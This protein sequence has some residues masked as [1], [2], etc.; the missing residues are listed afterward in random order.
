VDDQPK[1]NQDWRVLGGD[2]LSPR[3][4]IAFARKFANG[5]KCQFFTMGWNAPVW[6]PFRS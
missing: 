6:L 2:T 5:K 3:D 4:E 1:V